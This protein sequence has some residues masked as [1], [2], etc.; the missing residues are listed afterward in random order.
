MNDDLH[1][2]EKTQESHAIVQPMSLGISL[3]FFG[4]PA[5]VLIVGFHVAMPALIKGG[6]AP[7]YAFFV[8]FWATD[9]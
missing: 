3:L 7:F 5:L 8:G 2:I 4:M 6:I 9:S 1:T